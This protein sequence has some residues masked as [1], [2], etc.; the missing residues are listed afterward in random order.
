LATVTEIDQAAE[1]KT[2]PR[3]VSGG[4]KKR[5]A[6]RGEGA[7]VSRFFL[8]TADGGAPTLEREVESKKEAMLESFKTGRNYFAVSE[9]RTVPDLSKKT[10]QIRSEPVVREARASGPAPRGSTGSRSVAPA[11]VS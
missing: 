6:G 10:P 5:S 4:G 7:P 9:W 1:A 2:T 8:G 11:Q 3:R